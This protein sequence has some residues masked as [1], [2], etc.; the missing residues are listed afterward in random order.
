MCLFTGCADHE[1][2]KT[3]EE[4]VGFTLRIIACFCNGA[5]LDC[6]VI[7]IVYEVR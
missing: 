4:L 3:G 1:K 7:S 6:A 2:S 5:V